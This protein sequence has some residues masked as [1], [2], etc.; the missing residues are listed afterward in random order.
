MK[1]LVWWRSLA[2]TFLSLRLR[3]TS[4]RWCSF[5]IELAAL[6]WLRLW[7]STVDLKV[8]PTGSPTPL[9]CWRFSPNGWWQIRHQSGSWQIRLPIS[10]PRKWWILLVVQGLGCWQLQ[11]K[12]TRCLELK[13]DVSEFWSAQCRGCWKRSPRWTSIWLSI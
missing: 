11:Q 5:V 6:S 13:K 12:L 3:C 10:H 9:K 1:L 7:G 2:V 8:P 4:T